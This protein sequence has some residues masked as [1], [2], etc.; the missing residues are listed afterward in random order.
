LAVGRRAVPEQGEHQPERDEPKQEEGPPAPPAGTDP[1]GEESDQRV[2]DVVPGAADEDCQRR[3]G[4]F[5]PDHVGQEDREKDL[6]GGV[7]TGEA[8]ITDAIEELAQGGEAVFQGGCHAGGLL[9]PGDGSCIGEY[10]TASDRSPPA[11]N[12]AQLYRIGFEAKRA[13][14]PT[15]KLSQNYLSG[16]FPPLSPASMGRFHS[17]EQ[18]ALIS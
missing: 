11:E 4:G 7:S 10:N 9:G 15:A 3:V 18:D 14:R 2:V 1:V 16:F 17:S 8:E 12:L 6:H 5:Q 13:G